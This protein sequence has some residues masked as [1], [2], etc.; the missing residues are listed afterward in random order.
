MGGNL[1]KKKPTCT[2]KFDLIWIVIIMNL[3]YIFMFIDRHQTQ[4]G[5]KTINS[6]HFFV[7]KCQQNNFGNGGTP[8]TL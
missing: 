5:M 3:F 2:A 4:N 7:I 8:V 6:V 1:E